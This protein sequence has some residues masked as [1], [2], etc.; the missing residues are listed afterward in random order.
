MTR[1]SMSR[2][3]TVA[4]LLA[5]LSQSVPASAQVAPSPGAAQTYAVLGA[6]T[7]TNTGP[8]VIGGDLGLSPGTSVTGFP[9]GTVVGGAIHAG[10]AAALSA[11][12]SLTTAYNSAAGQSCTQ[13]LTGQDLGGKVLTPG[14][15]CFSTSAQLTGSLTLNGQG[16][17]SAVWIFKVGSTLTTASGSSVVMAGGGSQCNVF[18]QVG[19]S[20]T[21]GTSTSFAGNILA[22]SSIT[23]NTGA[24]I[25]GRALARNGAV[26]LDTNNITPTTCSSAAAPAPPPPPP[27]PAVCATIAPDLFVVKR[28]T[29]TFTVGVTSTYSIA[30]FNQGLASSGTITVT[31]TLPTGL[32][33]VSATGTTWS[34]SAAGQVVTCTTASV[35]G[36]AGPFP[37]NITLS[38]RPSAAA[39]PAVTNTAI[40]SGGNDCNL[41]NNSTADVTVVA[42]AVPTLPEWALI[43]LAILL[44][45][46]GV[47]AV[48]RRTAV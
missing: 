39:V 35:V 46:A 38:V 34:C 11:Q 30:V 27:T 45:G 21:V 26:T 25:I 28:H 5:L 4:A 33:F 36:A 44:C 37:N 6:S 41:V 9:P 7:V 23:M 29:D 20:A 3:T 15:Y 2:F 17:A 32:A 14:V 42:L 48:R 18:W 19:T 1:S 16:N 13:D 47:L 8:S 24:N 31:D 43:C 22:L 10:D 12:S 40:V